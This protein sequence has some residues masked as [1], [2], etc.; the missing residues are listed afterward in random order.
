MRPAFQLYDYSYFD[1]YA[2]CNYCTDYRKFGTPL[3]NFR[4][5]CLRMF[6]ILVFSVVF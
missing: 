5:T 3:F 1:D 2:I 4:D 6:M